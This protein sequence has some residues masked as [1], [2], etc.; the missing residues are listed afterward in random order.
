MLPSSS[1]ASPA[2]AMC[3]PA[4]RPVA[5]E[6]VQPHVVLHQRGEGRHRD[7]EAD[8]TGGEIDLAAVLEARRIG[9]HAAQCAQPR[10]LF[11][12]LAAEQVVD[13]VEH[14]PGMRLHR[15]AVLRAGDLEIER[16]HDG[17]HR[18]AGRLVPAHLQPVPVGAD[19]VGVVHHPR[20]QPQQLAFELVQQRH[21]LR[22]HPRS[23]GR[24][25]CGDHVHADAPGWR[26]MP[27]C[28]PTT[29][30]DRPSS[31]RTADDALRLPFAGVVLVPV[32]DLP[33]S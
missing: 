6:P 19:M 12:A 33:G 10:H 16:R 18:G 23:S 1:S 14:R 3:R 26:K 4:G 29:D 25:R 5:R 21:P 7:A 11:D 9:L 27:V 30:Q 17:D 28:P 2:I 20:R 24:R 31:R 15:D 22:V 32:L 8:R 13:G